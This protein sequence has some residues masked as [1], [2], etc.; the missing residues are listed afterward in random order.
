VLLELLFRA[1]SIGAI[2]GLVAAFDSVLITPDLRAAPGAALRLGGLVVM[3]YVGAAW[4]ATVLV[5]AVGRLSSLLGLAG[6]RLTSAPVLWALAGAALASGVINETARSYDWVESAKMPLRVVAAGAALALLARGLLGPRSRGAVA[7]SLER[8]VAVLALPALIG[9][10][11]YFATSPEGR[12]AS[13]GNGFV[14]LAPSFEAEPASSPGNAAGLRPRIILLGI[15]GASW[16]RIDRG[17]RGGELPTFGRLVRDGIR[18]PLRTLRPTY[19]PAI[20]TSI[21]TGVP[22]PAHGIEDFYLFQVPRLGLE[23]FRLARAADLAEE[24]LDTLGELRRVPVTSSLRRSKAVWNLADEAGLRT[25]VLGLWATWPPEPLRHGLV[26]SDHASLARQGEWLDRRKVS[27]L[28]AGAPTTH[29]PSLEER[30]RPL[31]RSP[32][33]VTREE[34]SGFL[35]VDDELW[36]EFQE[37]H[38]FSKGVLLSAFRSTHLNDSFYLRAGRA[39]WEE[40][41]LDFMVVYVKAIDELG[42][43]FYEAGVPE[44]AAL[45]WS[46]ED[47]ARFGG[48][49][50]RAYAWTDRMIAPLVDSVDRDGRTLLVVVSDHGWAKEADGGYN[51][52]EGPPGILILYGAGLCRVDCPALRDPSIYDVA[53]TLLERLSLPVSAELEGRPLEEA[54]ER[55]N[56]IVH[57]ARYGGPRHAARAIPSAVD[58][59]LTEKLEALG[60]LDD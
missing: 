42:H 60:Y 3:I 16:D 29:P 53:P 21:V 48:V 27:S 36:R 15:D 59:A 10:V 50:D 38:H 33:S 19:S 40:E 54:F 56:S 26:V 2:C 20:W 8:G 22:P 31:Q 51:H 28:D 6:D 30:L 44:A 58:G 35:P 14:S 12:V 37:I 23:R 13:G 5:A 45:G 7:R 41:R 34:L 17:I 18:A 4:G 9:T 43:F 47:V 39:L 32:D 46:P 11:A 55:P 1:T 57:V 24:T 49:M 25:A 52:N